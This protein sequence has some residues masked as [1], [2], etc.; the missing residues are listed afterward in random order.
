MSLVAAFLGVIAV[1]EI[2]NLLVRIV[3]V[4]IY[5]SNETIPPLDEDIRMKM[6]A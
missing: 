1:I 6:Y 3:K 2:I 4:C 5:I